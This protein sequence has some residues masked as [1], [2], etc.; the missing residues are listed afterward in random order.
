MDVVPVIDLKG[1]VVVHAR[2]GQRE[3]YRPIE[4]PL[5]QTSKP[6]D[7]VA[8]LLRLHPFRRLYVADLDAIERR[9]GHDAT[10]A[11]LGARFPDLE[12]WV[13]NGTAGPEEAGGW[14]ARNQGRLV[15][16]SESQ[17][18]LALLGALR[19]EERMVLSLDFRGKDFQGPPEL[20]ADTTLWPRRV[21]AMTLAQVGSGRGPDLSRLTEIVRCGDGR[22]VYAAGG[23]R[24]AADLHAIA[25]AGAAGALVATALHAGTVTATD[26]KDAA[27]R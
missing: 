22:E 20:L 11:A 23:V 6:E 27:R 7:V 1:G 2:Q 19:A 24:D 25:D 18:D 17:R 14:L 5:S 13:D 16:G 21:I 10:L 26:L 3:S 9:G 4:T 8:G 12:L 15:V